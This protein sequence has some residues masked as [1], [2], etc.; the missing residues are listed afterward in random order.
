MIANRSYDCVVIGGGP[1]GCT[2]A[3]IVAEQGLSTL[4]IERD[5]VP[6]FHVGESL[7]PESYFVLERL[8]IV[9]EMDRIGFTKKNGVQFVS[10]SD[11][12]TM[13]F[14]FR[15]HD[16]RESS[17]SWH[18]K[19]KE[20]DQLLWETAF[21]RG[22]TTVDETR[23]LDIEI[24][25]K[26]P[27]KITIKGTDGKEQEI[28]AKV[29]VDAS[30]QSAM[31]ANRL[32]IKEYYDDLKKAAIWG[33]FEGAKRAGGGKPE[34][35]CILHTKTKEA[36]FWYIPLADGTV[37]VGL[38]GDNDFVLKRQGPPEKAF[39]EEIANCPGIERR[40]QDATQV[41]KFNVAK[42]FSYCTTQQSGPGWVLVGDAGGFIDPIY[43]SG[44]YLALKSGVL[45]AEAIADGFRR[46]DLSGET[47]GKWTGRYEEGVSL[48]RKLVRAFYTNE[49]SFGEFIK[50]Y[51][52]HASNL[53]D[54]LIGRVFEG[55]PG[56]IFE[57]MDPWI[58]KI[59][60]GEQPQPA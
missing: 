49:F 31:I 1:G 45:A 39:A 11:K 18:V 4:L 3:A 44:V 19:R 41:G 55:N 5:K 13:P 54:L 24:R 38:V 28:V 43:S 17:D 47:L 33:Y 8:G 46:N 23:V 53:T 20:F 60:A 30:G 35:T 52:D 7:M 40:L 32:G 58:E 42:E 29:I 12:E 9:H 34:V 26:S 10:S 57:D 27:H 50:A 16:D 21:N 25:K 59:K 15:D 14:I 48:I 2:A 37:S 51:P 36:W 6:R 22:A 56:A